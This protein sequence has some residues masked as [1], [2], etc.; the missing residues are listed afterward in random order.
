M[1]LYCKHLTFFLG[2]AALLPSRAAFAF[3]SRIVT[4]SMRN[5]RVAQTAHK[6]YSTLKETA[7]QLGYVTPEQFDELLKPEDMVGDVK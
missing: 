2:K 7:V 6:N 5:V 4:F 1:F 3:Y